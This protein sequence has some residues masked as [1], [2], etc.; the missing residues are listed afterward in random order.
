MVEIS[1]SELELNL[2]Y[3]DNLKRLSTDSN[4]SKPLIIYE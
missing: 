4:S 3:E 1:R 2:S